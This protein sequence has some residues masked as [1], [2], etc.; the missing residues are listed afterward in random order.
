MPLL[1]TAVK[2]AKAAGIPDDRIFL[3]PVP[4]VSKRT[5]FL[6]IEDLIAEGAKLPDL[7]P[8][9]W[10]KG[11]SARQVAYLCYSSGTSGL[12]VGPHHDQVAI[13]QQLTVC[14]KPS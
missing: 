4:G 14:R 2:A 9:K 11:Q 10:I 1:D 3:L 5:P 13:A 12:P 7:E 8:L 6:T